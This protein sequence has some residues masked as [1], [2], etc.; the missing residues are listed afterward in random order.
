MV[1][2][3][4]KRILEQPLILKYLISA[5]A[6]IYSRRYYMSGTRLR[7]AGSVFYLSVEMLM[8]QS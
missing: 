2:L 8:M 1:S 5:R 6:G 4:Y 7:Y 3:F